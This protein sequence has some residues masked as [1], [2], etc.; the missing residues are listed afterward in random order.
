VRVRPNQRNAHRVASG[1]LGVSNRSP[2][3]PRDEFG[4]CVTGSHCIKKSNELIITL[5]KDMP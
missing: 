2:I 4:V 3:E 1:R 5:S